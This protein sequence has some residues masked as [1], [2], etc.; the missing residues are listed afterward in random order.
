MLKKPL[1]A[2][3]LGSLVLFG[4]GCKSPSQ[5][6]AEKATEG[7]INSQLGDKGKVD[8]SG[9]NLNFENGENRVAYGENVSLPKDFPTD[10][11]VY[12]GLKI[13]MATVSKTENA[14]TS[15]LATSTDAQSKVSEWYQ[16]ELESKGWAKDSDANS[17]A[18]MYLS[19]KKDLRTLTLGIVGNEENTTV[20][21]VV[22]KA[23]N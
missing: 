22:E 23:A 7:Y 18:G 19:Y 15:L 17:S 11:P 9:N 20:T 8:L 13:N 2:I 3:A 14:A 10:I 6:I 1:V 4:F 12:T 16:K 21:L 5:M